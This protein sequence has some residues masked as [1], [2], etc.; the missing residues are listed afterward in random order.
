MPE[1]LA[2]ADQV[3]KIQAI[4][5]ICGAPAT[6]SQRLIQSSKQFLLGEKD[7]YE[8][9]CRAHYEYEPSQ[10]QEILPLEEEAR[11]ILGM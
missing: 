3:T 11:P 2:I 6:R 4:C 5:T 1:L 7:A 8:P 9:R 10:S